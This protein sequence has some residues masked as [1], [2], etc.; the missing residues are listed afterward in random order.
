MIDFN[1]VIRRIEGTQFDDGYVTQQIADDVERLGWRVATQYLLN[2]SPSKLG[3]LR[4]KGLRKLAQIKRD[5]PEQ[6][7]KIIVFLPP[8]EAKDI[9]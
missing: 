6:F 7:E 2:F 3:T 1:E 4:L 8:E 5:K 9:I